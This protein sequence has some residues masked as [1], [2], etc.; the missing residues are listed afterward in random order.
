VNLAPWNLSNY[1]IIEKAGRIMVNDEALIFFHFHGFK[2]LSGSVYDTNLGRFGCKPS[3]VVRQEIFGAYISQLRFS[4]NT[5]GLRTLRRKDS[6]MMVRG[7]RWL[8][9]AS[10]GIVFRS[11]LV[12]IGDRVL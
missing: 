9:R 6:A 5:D 8:F 2:Q 7:L 12:V 11:Y 3:K 10:L 1:S 4:G